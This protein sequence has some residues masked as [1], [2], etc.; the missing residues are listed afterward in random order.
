L[1]PFHLARQLAV[2][3][4]NALVSAVCLSTV[5]LRKKIYFTDKTGSYIEYVRKQQLSWAAKISICF[6]FFARNQKLSTHFEQLL[7]LTLEHRNWTSSSSK[8]F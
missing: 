3:L 4:L 5:K 6:Y 1:A 7:T 2:S 8:I